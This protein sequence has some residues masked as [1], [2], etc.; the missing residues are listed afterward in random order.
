MGFRWRAGGDS[1]PYEQGRVVNPN[2]NEHPCF[3]QNK[4]LQVQKI[5]ETIIFASNLNF[6][7]CFEKKKTDL[8]SWLLFL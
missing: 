4:S 2:I 6:Y 3:E 1:F 5:P 7:V 8:K